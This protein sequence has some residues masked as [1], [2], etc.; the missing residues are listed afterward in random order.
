MSPSNSRGCQ[1][2]PPGRERSESNPQGRAVLR[3]RPKSRV[4]SRGTERLEDREAAGARQSFA[5][6][7]R[8]HKTDDDSEAACSSSV[9]RLS[10]PAR[11]PDQFVRI[12]AIEALGRMRATESSELLHS[13]CEK[14]EGLTHAEPAGLRAAAEDALAM[15]ENRPT[16]ARVRAVDLVKESA[17]AVEESSGE[18][19]QE[20]VWR[21]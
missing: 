17:V 20:L 8:V 9:R 14:R 2:T 16:S 1:V 3:S 12:K 19:H 6:R 11:S 10:L 21:R 7:T 5:F 18:G 13:I 15:M 4:F